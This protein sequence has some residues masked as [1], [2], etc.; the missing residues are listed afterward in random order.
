MWVHSTYR[1]KTRAPSTTASSAIR[2]NSTLE[3]SPTNRALLAVTFAFAH[4]VV[5][6][7]YLRPDL[8]KLPA[9]EPLS[10]TITTASLRLAQRGGHDV[11]ASAF[12]MSVLEVRALADLF[13]TEA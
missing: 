3:H 6:V 8:D 5:G 11:L 9:L 2:N 10:T 12:G 13:T 4:V 7:G 1:Q